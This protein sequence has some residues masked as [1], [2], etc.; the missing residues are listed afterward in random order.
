M[1]RKG[2]ISQRE[3]IVNKLKK[4]GK[5]GVLNTEL[6]KIG[7][8]YRT[9]VSE[10]YKLGYRI[11]CSYVGKSV[12]RYT[13]IQEPEVERDM[14]MRNAIDIISEDIDK[15]RGFVKK[16]ELIALM[17]H[18]GFHIVRKNGSYKL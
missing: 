15:L 16:E 8:G 2:Q 14:D 4:A 3:A 6:V 13:L 17:D 10:L 18:H 1:K 9:R 12:C 5:K 7:I 11:D